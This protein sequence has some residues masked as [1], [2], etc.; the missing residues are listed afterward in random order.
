MW[1]GTTCVLLSSATSDSSPWICAWNPGSAIDSTS[2]T[3]TL[4]Q[5]GPDSMR[6]FTFDLSAAS[7]PSDSNPFVSNSSAT[8]S[9]T[10]SSPSSSSNSNSNTGSSTVG[11]SP[12]TVADYEKAH[13]VI[14]ATTVVVL[15]PLGASSMRLFGN[16][17][18]HALLQIFS[19][20]SLLC[21]F[22][23][24]I[25]LAQMR[26]YVYA[27]FPSSPR[28]DSYLSPHIRVLTMYSFT[29]PQ[30]E[31]TPYSAPP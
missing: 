7:L 19:L 16:A 2:E 11:P 27:P 1:T 23:V 30:D 28:P 22:G 29:N 3:Y 8:N 10:A 18:I 6:Q 21:G 20:C 15:F 13:G 4:N 24:G 31:P 26:E 9:S 25:K 14:M 17:S 5:H 12:Q